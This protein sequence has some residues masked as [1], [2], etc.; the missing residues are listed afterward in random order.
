VYYQK[1]IPRRRVSPKRMALAILLAA[2]VLLAFLSAQLRPLLEGGVRIQAE[3]MF[4]SAVNAAVL[5]C[6]E[7]EDC[8]FD[9][10]AK[11][12]RL[13]SGS[14]AGIETDTAAANRLRALVSEEVRKCLEVYEEKPVSIP[15][16]TLL[17]ADILTGVGP[18]VR[19]RLRLAG[20]VT[21]QLESRLET[22]G[23]NQT[24]HTVECIVTAE[25][26]ALMPGYRFP[27]ELT[28]SVVVAQSVIVGETPD[29]FTYV[30]GDQSDTIGRIFDY[31]DP[32]GK[33]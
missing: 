8:Q 2:A 24:M 1:H 11:L 14:I 16:G 26:Y 19:L 17:G 18:D 5:G 9:S 29:S 23:I 12:N 22:A 20:G 3:N 6:F 13:D 27:V 31:G 33:D 28:T 30:Y 25:M 4:S 10:I 32:Y 7:A 15:M 21:A